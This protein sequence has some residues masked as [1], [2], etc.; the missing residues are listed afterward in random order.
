LGGTANF[1]SVDGS[2]RDYLFARLGKK[3]GRI[4]YSLR[5]VYSPQ[6]KGLLAIAQVVADVNQRVSVDVALTHAFSDSQSEYRM[7]GL[8]T[9]I[10]AAVRVRF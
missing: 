7:V 2:L 9:R 8:G 5:G 10:D 3:V 6:D 1:V 4:E